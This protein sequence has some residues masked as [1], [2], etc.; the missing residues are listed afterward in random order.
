LSA[1]NGD[2]FFGLKV[3][4]LNLANLC[5]VGF[6][7]D[8]SSTFRKGSKAAPPVIRK[9]T[10]AKF[11]DPFTEDGVDLT[12][13][14]R[15]YDYGDVEAAASNDEMRKNVYNVIR[16]LYNDDLRF[17][18]LGGDHLITYFTLHALTQLSKG[19]WALIYLD[20]HPD[21]EEEYEGDRYTHGCVVRRLVEETN[22]RP[23]S[24]VEVGIRSFLPP[25]RKF[26]DDVGIKIMS[27][28]EFE[29][30]GASDAAKRVLE[31]LPKDVER[32]Y[33]SI[34]LDIL[35]PAYA[36]GLGYPEA[37]GIS[38]RSLIDFIY[39]LR[40]SEIVAFDV[41]ELCPQY[42]SSSITAIGVG[43]IILEALG[44]MKPSSRRVA[45]K[46]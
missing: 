7:W 36:P 43:K 34:D 39:G 41:V 4:K 1:K 2:Y 44:I 45:S 15:V 27:T 6:P 35:D 23:Q 3:E 19:N 32:I 14:W 22:L 17:L 38:T 31:L 37:G 28:L 30:L 5:V 11:Y 29:R 20:A 13:I 12:R 9:I 42:D 40:G 25:E 21:L 46:L 10:T 33:L 8:I 18:F 24:V 16:N 26:A